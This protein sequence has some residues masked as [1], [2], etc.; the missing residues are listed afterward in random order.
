MYVLV[1]CACVHVHARLYVPNLFLVKESTQD[2]QREGGEKRARDTEG[3][4]EMERE[5][6]DRWFEPQRRNNQK[7]G[8]GGGRVGGG[9]FLKRQD[10]F[11]PS[12]T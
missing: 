1:W 3:E 4:L 7:D 8:V 9:S 6:G 11:T 10:S 5:R 2:G 12:P